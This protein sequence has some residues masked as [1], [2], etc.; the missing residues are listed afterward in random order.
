[1]N[2]F[3]MK[4]IFFFLI[5]IISLASCRNKT[6][7]NV[8]PLGRE[9]YNDKVGSWVIYQVDSIVYSDFN[10]VTQK[11]DTFNYQVKEL[12]SE[13]FLNVSGIET[14]RIE[15]YKRKDQAFSWEIINVWT[16]NINNS[17][18]EKV[19][20]N[21]RYTKLSFPVLENKVWPGNQYN[22]LS[23]WDYTYRNVDKPLSLNAFNFDHT[24][25]VIQK[26]SIDNNFIEKHFAR[27][28]YARDIGMIY[29]QVDTLEEQNS[30]SKG[31]KYR[32]TII[33]W[34]K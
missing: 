15:R 26:D 18:L 7:D 11:I 2:R 12:I 16:S 20:E 6:D 10:N 8:R 14:N 24:V 29:K 13:K 17:S 22:T 34:S 21:I 3:K 31:L 33:D 30:I 32:E 4:H 9:Y 28:I 5:L 1:M 27:E 23:P 19:E 25:T